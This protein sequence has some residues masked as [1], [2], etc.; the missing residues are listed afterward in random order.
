MT[1]VQHLINVKRDDDN[2]K[3]AIAQI[4]EEI[5]EDTEN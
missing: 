1:N 3:K 4:K 2:I 5:T